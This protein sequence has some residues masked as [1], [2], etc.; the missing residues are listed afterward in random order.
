MELGGADDD[1]RE[2]WLFNLF[3]I[4]YSLFILYF[5][6]RNT[7]THTQSHTHVRRSQRSRPPETKEQTPELSTPKKLLSEK[8]KH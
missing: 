8:V 1:Q 5:V 7:H 4:T 6:K 3:I 2:W